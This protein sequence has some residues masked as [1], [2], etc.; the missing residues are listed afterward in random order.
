MPENIIEAFDVLGKEIKA[1]K[2]ELEHRAWEI[3]TL[4]RKNKELYERVENLEQ[5]LKAAYVKLDKYTQL[6]PSEERGCRNG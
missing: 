4:N 6:K 1:L 2:R 3:D 5:E